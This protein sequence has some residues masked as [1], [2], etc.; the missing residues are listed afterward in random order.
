VRRNNLSDQGL[1]LKLFA[2]IKKE[3]PFNEVKIL[4]ESETVAEGSSG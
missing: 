2:L 3:I 4:K 1:A